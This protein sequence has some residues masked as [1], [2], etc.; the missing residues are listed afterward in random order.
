M[1]EHG[2]GSG[3]A[4]LAGLGVNVCEARERRGSNRLNDKSRTAIIG[5]LCLLN[6]STEGTVQNVVSKNHS[7]RRPLGCS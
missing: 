5:S 2:V 6:S 4:G 7:K 1:G 3:L